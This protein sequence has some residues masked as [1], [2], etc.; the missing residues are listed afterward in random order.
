[1]TKKPLG[2]VITISVLNP[3]YFWNK[4]YLSALNFH[5]VLTN[6]I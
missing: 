5:Y 2:N 6:L 1:M 4:S 3:E